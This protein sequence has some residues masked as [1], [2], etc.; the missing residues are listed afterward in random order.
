MK[1][2]FPTSII[3][4]ATKQCKRYEMS[5]LPGPGKGTGV[6]GV[7][8]KIGLKK[9]VWTLGIYYI[10]IYIYKYYSLK[11]TYHFYPSRVR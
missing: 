4:G 8:W 3:P 1:F 5:G 9:L 2:F 11:F 6:G 10:Y 7:S